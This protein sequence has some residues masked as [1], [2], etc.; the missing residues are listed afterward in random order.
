MI[1]VLFVC[2]GNICRSPTAEGIFRKLVD[3]QGLAGAIDVDSAGT[4]DWHIGGP[5]DEQAQ[6]T[7]QARGIDLGGLRAR[8]TRTDDFFAFDYVI[9][10]DRSNR[11]K[12]LALC[13]AGQQDR[14][15]LCLSFAPES[16]KTDVP[17]PY[18]E[19]RFDRVFDLIETACFGLLAE[20]RTTHTL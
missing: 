7:A 3:Q 8:Q 15:H 12:L 6:A 14:I 13:P 19:G 5:P 16:G 2:L 20:I 1:R 10:M 17:D 9:A 18:Y 11:Q 4:S